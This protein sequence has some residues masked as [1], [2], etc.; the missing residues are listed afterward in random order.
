MS[1]S[2]KYSLDSTTSEIMADPRA[3]AAILPLCRSTIR[4]S[5]WGAQT[6]RDLLAR[7]QQQVIVESCALIR[8]TVWDDC[9]AD[10]RAAIAEVLGNA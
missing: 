8:D 2:H 7:P 1:R 6:M 3:A 10:L 5:R 4:V 9:D